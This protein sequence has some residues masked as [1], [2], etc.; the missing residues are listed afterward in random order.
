MSDNYF[1]QGDRSRPTV[2]EVLTFTAFAAE[3]PLLGGKTGL[4]DGCCSS[5]RS[6]VGAGW[7]IRIEIQ[8]IPTFH[9]QHI[10]ISRMIQEG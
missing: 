2:A 4:C 3:A 9:A 7:G 5:L 6:M 1:L 8:L 10:I